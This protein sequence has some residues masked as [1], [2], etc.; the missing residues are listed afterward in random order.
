VNVFSNKRL[1]AIE[2]RLAVLEGGAGDDL[3]AHSARM[4]QID[5][6]LTHVE[7]GL[8]T[9]SDIARE[10]EVDITH[11]NVKVD[12]KIVC[13]IERLDAMSASIAD[14]FGT[15]ENRLAALE[16]SV[17][18][19]NRVINLNV[20]AA[21]DT[22]DRL[23]VLEAAVAMLVRGPRSPSPIAQKRAATIPRRKAAAAASGQSYADARLEE[24][25]RARVARARHRASRLKAEVQ[26][27]K[28]AA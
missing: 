16:A 26:Q 22:D 13:L 15:A 17:V 4:D 24:E 2:A 6:N 5:A 10:S 1:A 7:A 25:R 18:N 14:T 28:A 27:Q 12:T 9:V 3:T 11:L 8:E 19:I 23:E 21:N 20:D